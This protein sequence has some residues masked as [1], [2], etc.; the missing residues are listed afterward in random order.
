VE[1]NWPMLLPHPIPETTANYKELLVLGRPSEEII[2]TST[3]DR[4]GIGLMYQS[5]NSPKLKAIRVGVTKVN[6]SASLL[7]IRE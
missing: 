5:P 1:I 3:G 6:A 7:F 2:W 4:V